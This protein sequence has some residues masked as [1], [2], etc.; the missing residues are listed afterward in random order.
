MKDRIFIDSYAVTR[1]FKSMHLKKVTGPDNMSTF[2]LKKFAEE[3]TPAWHQLFQLS[4]D[5]R[6]I[7]LD[8]KKVHDNSSPEKSMS[9]GGQ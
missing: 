6:T 1:V 8:L 9:S 2:L 7:P 4:T 5:K 3:L